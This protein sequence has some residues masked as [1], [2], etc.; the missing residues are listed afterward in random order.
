MVDHVEIYLDTYREKNE[1]SYAVYYGHQDP[2][3]VN[4]TYMF[5]GPSST[6]LA[7]S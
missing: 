2:R 3:S 5:F 7:S 4:V 6:C 1:F